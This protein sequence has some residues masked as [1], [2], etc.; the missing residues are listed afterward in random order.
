MNKTNVFG[1][2]QN[3]ASSSSRIS[4]FTKRFAVL[5]L[6][7]LTFVLGARAADY[8]FTYTN[9]NNTY[10][11][12]ESTTPTTSFVPNASIYSGTSGST[13]R[14]AKNVYIRY[15]DGLAFST[16]TG[17]NLT[18][19]NNNI[20]YVEE[21]RW[22][23]TY[24]YLNMRNAN[25]SNRQW[26]MSDSNNSRATAYTVTTSS[27]INN[28]TISGDA[29]IKTVGT[30]NYTHTNATYYDTYSFNN[31]TY[32]S[33]NAS[34]AAT[35]TVPT[36]NLPSINEGYTWTISNNSY[37]TVNA[38]TGAITVNSLPAT[39]TE[40]T[41][42]CS[43]SRNGVTKT[44]TTTITLQQSGNTPTAISASD[45]SLA[46]A[47]DDDIS[48][49][50]TGTTPI[51]DKVEATSS[52]TGIF[53]VVTTPTSGGKV[54]L[55]PVAMGNATL[56]LIAKAKDGTTNACSTTVNI[57]VAERVKTPT[58]EYESNGAKAL[59]TI[60]CATEGAT[61]Y[62][63]IDGSDPTTSS[64][65][66]ENP[67]EVDEKVTVKAMAVKSG[68]INSSVASRTY[69]TSRPTGVDGGV[70]TLNDLEDHNWTY[71]S[72]VDRAVDGGNYND[73]YVG[74][75]YSPNPRNVKITY[76]ANGGAVSID[77]S[78][79]SFVYFKTLEQGAT[80]GQYP[81][82]VISNPFS[83]RPTGKGFGGWKIISGGEYIN[84]YNNGSTLPLD[85]EITFV[86]LP[87]PST[88]CISAEIV[89]EA[90]W[91][92]AKVT[93]LATVN[94][95]NNNY[96]FNITNGSS[97]TTYENN[98]LVINRNYSG[99][100]T[101][102]QP[103]T[104]MMVEP[105]ATGADPDYRDN[106]TFT[107]N[108]TPNN[109]GVTK[110]E[111]AK[112]N[113]QNTLNCNNHSV[114]IGRGMVTTS[115]C[116]NYVTGVNSSTN[117]Y[118][119]PSYNV[120]LNYHLK[121]ES[122][123]FTDVSF[124]AG[125]EETAGYV[126]C[127]GTSNQIKGTLGNDY[128]RAK[129]DNTK[130]IIS[131]ELFLGY[132]PTYGSGNQNNA[133][134]TCW[135][136]SGNLCSETNVTNTTF[137]NQ[138]TPNG[139][140]YGDANQVFY[141]SSGGAQT[142]IGKRMLYVEGGILSGIAGGIDSN[143]PAN[144]ESFF[145]RMTGGQVRGV[146]YG[147]G[148]FAAS[149]GIRRMIFTG[150]QING[151]IA[152]G[153]NGTDPG[154]SGGTLPS[155]TYIYVGGNTHIGNATDLTLNTSL[156]GN[157]F[158]AGS[159]NSAQATT[160]Q[161]NNSNVVIAD[162]SYIKNNVYGG[163]N[164]G[165]S[166]A[167]ASVYV[168]GGEVAGS[169]FGGSNQ[170]Q[171]VVV[172]VN[173]IGG[174]VDK[175]VYGGS[176][177]TGT[178]S[179]N[180]TMQI[181]GGQVGTSS[182]PAN[183]HGG[184]YGQA[185]RVSGNVEVTLGT[186]G[187]AT[188]GVTVYGD[189]YGGSALGTVNSDAND[190][191]YVTM[192]KGTINGSL[193]GGGLGSASVAANVN[194]PVKVEVHGGSVKAT[195]VAGSGGVYGA[196]NINGAPQRSV[197]VDIYG[198]DPAPAEG[199]YALYA[200]YGGGNQ[201]DYLYGN[202]YPTVTV[203]GCDNS[204]EY[205]YG[206]GNAAAVKSTNV[207]I[208][209]G[210]VI[211]NVFGGGHGYKDG[212]GANV[213]GDVNLAIKGGTI[214]RVFGG[215]NSKGNI[216]GTINLDINK[217]GACDMRIGEVY[218][219]GNEADGNAGA[220]TIGCTGALVEGDE[221]HAAHPENIG[222]IL[223]GIGAVYG[224]ANNANVT[225]A[226]GITLNINS[227]MVANVFGGNN[228]GG[229]ING[230][231]T[232]NVNKNE[233]TCGWYVGNVFGGGNLAQYSGA[234]AVNIL[235]GEVS[236]NVYGGGKG[237]ANDHSK[238][239][240]T[241]NPTVTIGDK[242]NAGYEAIV[243]GDVYGGG[244]AGNVVGI[245]VV[246]VVNKCNT[247]IGNVYGGGNAADVEGTDVNIDGGTI[248][249]MV[250]G[251][252]HGDKNA[253][254]QTEANVNGNVN[255]DITGGTI[256]K[257]FGGSNSKG[258][259][260]GTIALNIEKGDESCELHITEVY[261][262]G[263]EAAGNAGVITIGCTG[264]EIEG[265]DDVYGGANAADINSYIT[266]NITGGKINRVFGGNNASGSISGGI[267]VNV[268]WNTENPCGVNYLGNVYG[269]GNLAQYG[270]ASSNKGNYPAVNILN[271]TVS[272]HVFG[273]GLGESAIV[274][275]N[276]QVTIGDN[277]ASHTA[278]V[279]GDV[280]GGGD[281]A[282]VVGTPVVKVVNDCNT[283][284][285]NVYGG[286]NAADVSATSVTIDGGKITGMVFGGGHGDKD[287]EPQ[288]EA[289]VNGNVNVLVTGGT[290][291]KVF[292]GSNSKGNIGGVINLIIEKGD[293]SCELHIT[294]VY[295]GG[296]EAAGNAGTINIACT[297][298]EGE[299]IGDV[300]GGANA[301]DINTPITLNITGGNIKRVFGGNNTSGSINGDIQVNVDW[302]G[303]CGVNALGNVYGAGNQAA[304]SGNTEVNILN[305]TVT[306]SVYGGGLGATA[307]VTG[308]TKVNIDG[309]ADGHSVMVTQNVL[310]GGDAAAVTG[311]T[312]VNIINGAV[313]GSVF[314]G[315]NAAGVSENGVVDITGGTIASGVYGGSNASGAVGNTIVTLTNGIIGTDAAHANVHGG[316][317]GQ[318]TGVLGNVDILIGESNQ[319]E[320][321]V[322]IY[323]DVYGGSALGTVNG[324]SANDTYHTN[325][326]LNKGTIY[327]SLYGGALGS[328]EVAANVYAPVTVTVNGGSVK[329]TAEEGSGGVYGANNINGAPQH[330]VIVNINATDPAPAEGQYA[331]Y[332]V[333][334]G[335]NKAAYTYGK[336]YPKVT[337]Y[338]CDNSIEYVYG[339][340]NAAAV[341]GTN[342]TVWGGNT[343][344]YVFG[345]GHGYKENSIGADVNGDVLVNIHGGTIDKVF[346]GSNSMGNITG[347]ISLNITKEGECEMHI[348]EVYGGGNE[349]A[350]NAGTITIGC[351]GGD[352]EGIGDVYGGANAADINSGI[353]LN[354]TGGNISR[355]FGGNNASG[356]VSGDIVVNVDWT[357]TCGVNALGNVYGAGNLA[358]YSGK[359]AVNILNGTV[360][361]SVFGGGL[362]DKA[363]VTGTTL[364][365]INQ[366][367][368]GTV[369][370]SQNVFG[371]GD[372]AEVTGSTDVNII[373]GAV[374]GSVF[375]GGNAAGVSENGVVDITG[376]TIASGVYGGSN[377]SGAVGNTTVT[378]TNGTIGTDAA[379][380]NVHGGGYGKDTQVSGNV[381]VNI[382]GGTVY[383][384]VYGG[385]ALG[386]V[387]TN[388]SNTTVVNL[389]GGIIHGDAYGGG[390][391]D[392]ET[393]ADVNGNVTVTLDGTAF[394]LATTTDD[395]GNVI[396]TSGRV[397]GC[398]NINGS[399]K[400]TVLVQ[401]LNTVA[402]D[403]EGNIKAKPNKNSGVYEL[404]AVYG[405]GNLAAY[406]PTDQFA[407]GQ[408]S[409]YKIDVN[410]AAAHDNTDKP[411]QVV[412]DACDEASIEYVY[413]GGNAA[414]T[415]ATDVIVLGSYEIGN[416][417]GGGN[418]KDKYKLDGGSTWYDNPGADVGIIDAVAYQQNTA[419]GKYGTGMSK[420]SVLGGTV[421]NLFGASNTKGN[422][423][424][425][426]LAYVDNAGTCPLNVGG[427]YGGGNEAYMDGDSKIE[428]GCIEALEEIY[429]GARNADVKGDINLTISSGHFDRVF[430][431]NNIGGTINGS[432][433]V[434]IEETG[435]NP[436][437]I[438]ELYGCGNQAPYTTPEGEDDP[439]I[440]LISFTS[441][442]NVFGG[443]FGENAVVKGNPTVNID[444]K[445][446]DNRER[447]W[448]Y[449]G[450]TITFSDGSKVTLPVHE[451]GKIGVIGTVY[452]G[453]N[454]AAVKGNTTVKME[455]GI[456]ENTVFGGGNAA[457]V[458]GDTSV[459][460]LDGTIGGN[461]YGGGNQ[462]KV[463]G[464]TKVQIGQQPTP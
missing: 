419:N 293:E 346:G 43:V 221:G 105:N 304:Y 299:G 256:N 186:E 370:V 372:A 392:S 154:Q 51:Y 141:V 76:N 198:T 272:G 16:T 63:T 77:E 64:N 441:I 324:T 106:Y 3:S 252:G 445:E 393:E 144:N 376:G 99:T 24:Y 418:G 59:T 208:W 237:D 284:I 89:F 456:V 266:L 174:Q 391:G 250:F 233:E 282:N 45:F 380:A 298:G 78:E 243:K 267:V 118:G 151:W 191:T 28:L 90:T 235:N 140:Y 457:D 413:G 14:N 195:S 379:H 460:I 35:T 358:P 425:E 238:G 342:V 244:D 369:V 343:I 86:N 175:G 394:V 227:G 356:N 461:V 444:V 276:P 211:G 331:L 287:A 388:T 153:C 279:T 155:D 139:G 199:E 442:G 146:V 156:D 382:Q 395:K 6:L 29:T 56:T 247:T 458:E 202:G 463:T 152:A 73:N 185:T 407:E 58:I 365:N 290:I 82:T 399:P 455:N 378:L 17:T 9:G 339:G 119:S 163:G 283:Q 84:G 104:I 147:S 321:G 203:H 112:W 314:G 21:G 192:Y 60:T 396:P 236:G 20:A 427:I 81:Y 4:N 193:Y 39:E 134:F 113:S 44:A 117:N 277:N 325:V 274:Y 327:G 222:K 423:V 1:A 383:G 215:S 23:D 170:K 317:Y 224:G 46:V 262:G 341:N 291:N 187:Q 254:P 8:V 363:I 302:S 30:Y 258:N 318:E 446:G 55:H 453:G 79:T 228:T 5:T 261:G 209:G 273:G 124:I 242:S 464:A 158:G 260:T 328:D 165:Y 54:T 213:E 100:L 114:T 108:I 142:N 241:G 219:G 443:G 212:P 373:A 178:I 223:E 102:S 127:N 166:N 286:G 248:T 32:Y 424:T 405:G 159:G 25:N 125:T 22:G 239:Q 234:P 143:N 18:I 334:G 448:A 97:T 122:G 70:V 408:F 439:I 95:S 275:G 41:L 305:G 149:S 130:L 297:G 330:S 374:A 37:A 271:G 10:F 345:G 269:A 150:G 180:V 315:G 126:R 451:K 12:G 333:Y 57:T 245:P 128:D 189:V 440:N 136:K 432:I 367:S 74:K 161:V 71:Y 160:G 110:I 354:I 188:G 364:V 310:G 2:V 49:I 371:G 176:N 303:T 311:S 462:G 31:K 360:T 13:F 61:I 15:N 381:A 138:G 26:R 251:G 72:G 420:A 429:G 426:S 323:G 257:V 351:T 167:I 183:I 111:Y 66:Y 27:V 47:T 308:T 182:A 230:T 103:V 67:F 435:C 205:V 123:K 421:H 401:V 366:E 263:N 91:V 340:G 218:G 184:G 121:L 157:V 65:L 409:S 422:V 204:I 278:I 289:N 179:E 280:Y 309:S 265:I 162:D 173:M 7:L 214:K 326:T 107:G 353:T 132:Q 62:Y 459:T 196:N 344:G 397:F 226:S 285:G 131:D 19:T 337:I 259:I 411:V 216:S 264:S 338:K 359:T 389:T 135:V 210:N 452:G 68:Y 220:V 217:D 190:H 206:G 329:K 172:N 87:Y 368:G 88:N 319:T 387:N 38:S 93:Y 437:T 410:T 436:I 352:G 75:L 412:I 402:R 42:T 377:A 428:L 313:S 348:A 362:G 316:G 194:G 431:G 375:G 80:A 384:D 145:V 438:G 129:E 207:T 249:G 270:S 296:N 320:G 406:N 83:K 349:A 11:L 137:N 197:T 201:A 434:T 133:T 447:D 307:V 171:G 164:Y 232:V 417:F 400:G 85:Q 347:N 101:L 449:N 390:L 115:Q 96:T 361:G 404:N 301:A 300:Y 33:T 335:G 433:T 336:G 255:L 350:G 292:G 281:A 52:N 181:N 357:G 253:D 398:N 168:T 385:S 386:T 306:G 403:G 225:N 246:N 169:V 53:T 415:P 34:Q 450:Q 92:N 116:A 355:V 94:N 120:N 454:A 109:D 98:F 312:D 268:N 288:T 36:N 231:I 414:P 177:V 295:G 322:E 332:A 50:L 416:V 40:L 430:G 69:E 294:E 148:A 200:V 48:Y 240:V 229:G